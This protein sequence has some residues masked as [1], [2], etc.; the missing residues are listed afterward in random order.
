MPRS[1]HRDAFRSEPLL[2][3]PHQLLERITHN[4]RGGIIDVYTAWE[5]PA[6]CEAVTCLSVDPDALPGRIY[7]ISYD[8]QDPKEAKLPQSLRLIGGGGGNRTVVE[9]PCF[10]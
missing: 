9:P 3:D 2:G 4:A 7:D 6:L 1:E 10:A 5:W 8:K